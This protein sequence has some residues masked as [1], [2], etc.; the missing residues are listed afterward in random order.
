MH[1]KGSFIPTLIPTLGLLAGLLSAC[2][3]GSGS[4]LSTPAALLRI[5][6]NQVDTVECECEWEEFGYPNAQV[7]LDG[8]LDS[9]ELIE[10][11]EEVYPEYAG[12][13]LGAALRCALPAWQ[14]YARCVERLGCGGYNEAECFFPFQTAVSE[15]P[16]P[17]EDPFYEGFAG[18]VF[19]CAAAR[20][21]E[22]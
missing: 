20:G 6:E 11:A 13:S 12:T 3:T 16:I 15:C 9:D 7:C 8:F 21:D 18:E 1:G 4:G 17:E 5:A 10:C 19:A 14:D 2:G 22:G